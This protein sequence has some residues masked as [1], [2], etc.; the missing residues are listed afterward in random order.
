MIGPV[1]SGYTPPAARVEAMMTAAVLRPARILLAHRSVGLVQLP[2]LPPSLRS[3][4]TASSTAAGST[5]LIMSCSVRPA[6]ATAVKRLHLHPGPVGG[7]HRGRDAHFGVTHLEIDR[8]AGDRYRVAERHQ[9]GGPFRR[10]DAGNSRRRQRITL[11]QAALLQQLRDVRCRPDDTGGQRGPAGGLFVRDIDHPGRAGGIH[12]GQPGHRSRPGRTTLP[13]HR[14]GPGT[15]RPITA[16]GSVTA[17]E[18]PTEL[19]R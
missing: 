15:P 14:S 1:R 13:G 12:M 9:V 10:H 3:T 5:A 11:G 6:T 17:A 7:P 16:A 2:V 19:S 18:P 4:R 8:D